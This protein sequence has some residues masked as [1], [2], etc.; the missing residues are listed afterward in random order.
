MKKIRKK[1][2]GTMVLLTGTSHP[3]LAQEI[4]KKLGIPLGAVL[5]GRF[6]EGEI[7]LQILDNIRGKDVFIVQ[8]TCT[9]PNESL[10]ELL[11]LIDASRRASAKRITAVLPFTVADA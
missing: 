9:P 4:A 1:K 3:E 11:I 8:P 5:L 7:Q 2:N 6:P 10:M